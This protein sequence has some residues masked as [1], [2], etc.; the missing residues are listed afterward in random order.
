MRY[1][2]N[3]ATTLEYAYISYAST[4]NGIAGEPNRYIRIVRLTA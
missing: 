3:G 1:C 2:D 4:L